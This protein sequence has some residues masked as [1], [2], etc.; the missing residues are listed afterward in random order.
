MQRKIGYGVLLALCIASGILSWD[1]V[2]SDPA[3]VSKL[4]E[5]T[6]CKVKSCSERHGLTK[7]DRTPLGQ[8]VE[9]T[10]RDGTVVVECSRPYLLVGDR[11]CKP[12]QPPP[13]K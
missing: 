2:L 8:T 11:A 1:N 3:P 4:A 12:A 5:E 6:A 10:W 9:F 7:M 13:T